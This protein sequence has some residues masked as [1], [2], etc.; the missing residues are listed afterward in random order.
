MSGGTAPELSRP[1]NLDAIARLIGQQKL[2]AEEAE[3]DALARRFGYLA[4]DGLEADYEL[5]REGRAVWAKGQLR[6]RLSQACVATG[7]PVIE[8]I[9]QPFLIR[10]EPEDASR[11]ATEEE[12]EID[13]QDADIVTYAGERIDMGEAVAETLA[14]LANPYPRSANADEWLRERGVKQEGETGPFAALAQ[15]KNK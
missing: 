5:T 13:A 1:V 15:L 2:V 9:D 14:L 10:F 12:L 6:A 8:N 7:E 11:L 4:L 3:R